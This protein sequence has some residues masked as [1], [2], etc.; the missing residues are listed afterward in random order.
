MG[1]LLPP[2]Y[3]EEVD[4]IPCSR[5]PQRSLSR[6]HFGAVRRRA[7]RCRLRHQVSVRQ[8]SINH[9]DP[10]R[11]L[12]AT[13]SPSARP[14]SSRLQ[15]PTQNVGPKS[16][17]LNSYLP[18]RHIRVR[19]RLVEGLELGPWRWFSRDRPGRKSRKESGK[20]KMFASR[21]RRALVALKKGHPST[22][23]AAGAGSSSSLAVGAA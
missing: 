4:G 23:V 20:K 1:A 7:S 21:P 9:E 15:F 16:F 12:H 6:R 18:Q 22:S 19:R 11:N 13:Q 5:L 17:L 2:L 8:T 14:Y 3:T 10:H